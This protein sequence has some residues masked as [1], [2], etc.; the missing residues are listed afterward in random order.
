MTRAAPYPEP[1]VLPQFVPILLVAV[2][3]VASPLNRTRLFADLERWV[4]SEAWQA[5]QGTESGAKFLRELE[6]DEAWLRD[7]MD[8]GPVRRADVVLVFLEELWA[9]D[10]GLR[11]RPVDRGMATACALAKGMT[12]YDADWMRKRYEYYRDSHAAGLLNACYEG[13]ATWER[14][15]LARGCQWRGFADAEALEFLREE[16]CWPRREYVHACWQAP[17]RSFNSLADSVQG[18]A[19]Y[20]PFQGS[21]SCG[22]EMAIDVGGVCGALSNLGASAAMANGIPATTMG[23]PGHCAYAVKIDDTTWQPAYSLSWKRGMHTSFHEATWPGLMLTE[24]CFRTPRKVQKAGDL[25]RQAHA[26]ERDGDL[27]RADA[28]WRRALAAHGLH[29]ELWLEW[30]SFGERTSQDK[31]WWRDYHDAL[32]DGLEDHEEPAWRILSK[33]VYPKLLKG[34]AEADKR[35]LFL[36]W[37]QSCDTWGGGRWDVESAWNWIFARLDA[38]EQ[39]RLIP[40]MSRELIEPSAFGPACVAW[41]LGLHDPDSKEWNDVLKSLL[42]AMRSEQDGA[43]AALKQLARTTIPEAAARGDVSTFQAIG[44]A[45]SRLSEPQPMDGI[46]PFEGKLL[47]D[48]G[49][50]QVSGRGN[51]WD[52]P[53]HHWGVLGEHGGHCHTDNGASFIAV[54]LEHHAELTGIVIQNR[55]GGNMWRA[56]GSRIEISSDGESWEPIGALEGTHAIYR[57]GFEG[58]RHRCSWVRIAKDTNCLHLHRFLVYGRRRS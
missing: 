52:S 14:R 54:R 19:Y 29:Y 57:V 50:L 56:G 51:R 47:S 31:G 25:A 10:P 7:L 46:E 45:A 49:L 36:R 30:A 38:K 42:R 27:V 17:Y 37:I 26:A 23:E 8:S 2:A 35:R 3:A 16:I 11:R 44:K 13:L 40:V 6:R 39:A 55:A 9:R 15:Y 32:V 12:D 22:P 33:R 58:E 28:S 5:I 34:L 24:A 21:Y 41:L 43:A 20:L 18:P 53:E 48:G 1:M 4:G